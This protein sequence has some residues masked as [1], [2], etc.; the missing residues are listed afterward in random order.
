MMTQNTDKNRE[1]IQM[2]CMDDLVPQDHLLRLIDKAIDWS[3][4]YD[5]VEDKYCLDNGRPSL[6]PVVLIKIPFIQY[7]YGI[8]SMRQTI[9]DIEV[10]VAYRW[11]LGLEMYDPVPHFSTF[12]KNY[13]RRFK[14]TDLFEQIF[15]KIL[16]DCYKW[17]LVDPTE[18][19]VDATHVKARANNKKMRKRIAQEEALFYEELLKK[20]INDDREKKGKKPLKEKDNSDDNNHSSGGTSGNT[21]EIKESTTDPESG[22]F[23]KGEHKQVFAYSIETACDKNGWILGY[24]VSPGNEHD[25]RTFKGLFD[26]IEDIGIRTLIADAGYKTPAIA[27][28]L[29]DKGITP[30][31]PYKQPM[32]KERFF[33]KYEYVY[34]EY[35]DCYI[36]PNN[37]ILRYSTTNRDGYKEYKSCKHICSECPYLSQCTESRDHVKVVTRHIWEE[38]MEKCEDIRHTLGMKELYKLRK[39]TIE[40]LFGTAKENH[41]FRYTQMYGKARM[42]MKVGLTYACLNLK[43]LA[44]MLQRK[45]IIGHVF[46]RFSGLLAAA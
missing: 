13:T 29:I 33:K 35:Y 20:E 17:K 32:T 27:K 12:G 45:G 42:E 16:E 8:K 11:F 25:S 7:L 44:R 43:K 36:C 19:F 21:K 10:N 2:F 1:Q 38:Y 14:D 34:D 5:L 24:T 3:F 26:K 22:W 46:N 4:I 30:L 37:Q 40:R 39:E 23:H 18:V 41:N 15:A 9:K 28:L 31:F 6:D